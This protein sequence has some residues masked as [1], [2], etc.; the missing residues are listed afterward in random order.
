MSITRDLTRLIRTKPVT[1]SDLKWAVL[2]VLDTLG[3]TLCA[4]KTEPAR[5]LRAVAAPATADVARRAFYIGDLAQPL[6]P[7]LNCIANWQAATSRPLQ[8]APIRQRL[9]CATGQCRQTLF[10]QVFTASHGGDRS[11]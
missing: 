1:D 10:G 11:V 9:I 3:Y 8:S 5:L 2:F 4:Q 7:R 6:A